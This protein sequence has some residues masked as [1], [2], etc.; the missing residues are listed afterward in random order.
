MCLLDGLLTWDGEGAVCT[1]RSHLDPA[2]PLRREG[3]LAAIHAIEYAGQTAALHCA[4]TAPDG[5]PARALLA[6]V[7]E[8]R[9]AR[10]YLDGLDGPIE[11]SARRELALGGSA[12]YRFA[13]AWAGETI[14]SGR[15]T[16]AG[17]D[18]GGAP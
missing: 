17:A 1:A 4:L 8:V 15:L 14:A 9:L 13:L 16:V 6:A 11:V 10:P 2:N 12:I 7:G 3:R 5:A 18:R